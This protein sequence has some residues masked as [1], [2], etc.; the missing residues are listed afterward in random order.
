VAVEVE[1]GKATCV[2]MTAVADIGK[3]GNILAVEGQ[4]YGGL[5]HGISF[6]LKNEY[7]DYKKH[8]S[9]AGA[10]VP[11]IEEIPDKY[12]IIF[13]DNPRKVGP[14][15]SSGCAETFQSSGHVSVINAIYNAVGARIYELPARPEKVK[16]AMDAKARG[17][18]LKP[19]KYFLGGDL[20]D[21]LEEIIANPV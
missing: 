6:A 11:Y 3:V 4:G 20:Y 12:E 1:T 19:R 10:G 2:G 14:F 21:E 5:S 13:L 18:E 17:E 8:A 7:Q 15:G 9:I 16:A